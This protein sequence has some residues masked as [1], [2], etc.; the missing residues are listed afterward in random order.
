MK[1]TSLP[2]MLGTVQFGLNYGIANTSGKPSLDEVKAILKYAYDHNLTALD[3][4]RAYGD[5]EEVIGKAL[6]DLGLLDKFFIVT[7][8]PRIP[9]DC[10]PEKFIEQSL[11]E[12]GKF[13]RLDTIP[14]ALLHNEAD[15]KHLPIAKK[16]VE[17]GLIGGTGLSLDSAACADKAGDAEFVQIPNNV[18]DHR[19][20]H[21]FDIPRKATFIRSVYLQGM[22][23]MPE[24]KVPFPEIREARKKLEQFGIPLPELCMRYL[25]TQP[26]NPVVLTGVEK[27]EQLKQNIALAE[28]GPLDAELFAKVKSAIQL[29]E[30]ITRPSLWKNRLN[31]K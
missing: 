1:N 15:I 18:V 28:K 26:G 5:S 30:S 22:L 29:D 11:C 31:T 6:A 8:I 14:V 16:M 7:K 21:L 17:K 24:D 9:E 10:D 12:S 19:F 13:L 27:L 4:S 2:L 25:F 20:D 23:V 3:T